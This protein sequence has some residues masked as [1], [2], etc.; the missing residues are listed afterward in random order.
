MKKIKYIN[1][2]ATYPIGDGYKIIAHVNNDIGAWGAGFVLAISKRW[3]LPEKEYKN[4]RK[5]VYPKELPL[6]A[7][8][9]IKVEKDIIVANMIG[10]HGIKKNKDGIPPIRYKAI[11]NALELV[12]K[13][14]KESNA[15]VHMPK[16]GAGLA[17]G[18]WGKIE[19]IIIKTLCTN[20]IDTYVYIYK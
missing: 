7:V 16:I 12:C 17:G 18:E 20:D 15:S 13:K 9:F 14:A 11:E 19:E 10:Q 1:G 2:D 8:Q 5:S 3:N 4:W 6:G